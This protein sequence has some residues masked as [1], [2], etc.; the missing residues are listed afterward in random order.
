VRYGIH[1]CKNRIKRSQRLAGH[2]G[3]SKCQ[4]NCTFAAIATYMKRTNFA[5]YKPGTFIMDI[6]N[7][8]MA[9]QL[10]EPKDMPAHIHEY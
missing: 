6:S 10:V 5:A 9:A 3:K 4:I 2:R 8:T 1:P 7:F